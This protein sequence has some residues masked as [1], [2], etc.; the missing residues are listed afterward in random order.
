MYEIDKK[1]G[2]A[3]QNKDGSFKAKTAHTLNPVPLI[4]YD[5]VSG[6][7]LGL[8]PNPK[9]GL[10]NIAATVANLLGLEKHPAWDES[11]LEIR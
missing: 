11:L 10:S 7:R 6:G 9:A 3:A 5:N 8:K 4:L 2:A 1:T